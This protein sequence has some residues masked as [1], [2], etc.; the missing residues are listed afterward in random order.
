SPN[1]QTFP[2]A[3]NSTDNSLVVSDFCIPPITRLARVL[4]CCLASVAVT[5]PGPISMK[6]PPKVLFAN[7]MASEKLTVS[8]TWRTQYSVLRACSSVS[9]LPVTVDIIGLLGT[10]F[11]TLLTIRLNAS[12]MGSI[13]EEWKAWLVWSKL[14][15]TPIC[16]RCCLYAAINSCGPDTTQSL[17]ALLAA[18][19]RPLGRVEAIMSTDSRTESMLP[20]GNELTKRPRD[21]INDRASDNENTPAK[22]APTNSPTLCPTNAVGSTPQLIH[23]LAKA[24]SVTKIAGCV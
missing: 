11:S 5:L 16:V 24:Y 22:Q 14:V 19:E 18:I 3:S 10:C 9:Q 23:S 17:G 8:R 15:V 21:A 1:D 13:I 20:L 4:R 6:T 12:N 7:M 2:K